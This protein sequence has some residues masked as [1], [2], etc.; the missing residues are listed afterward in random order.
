MARRYGL[1]D[2]LIGEADHALR[3]ALT[4]AKSAVPNPAQATD[5]VSLSEQ[6]KHH[7]AGLMRVDHTG[8]VW[9]QALYRGQ[10]MVARNAE[11]HQH[12]LHAADEEH[13]HLAWCAERLQ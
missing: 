7:S 9:A 10:A 2:R 3:T 13:A 12:L 4:V 8:E 11:T 6:D 1:L 5:D